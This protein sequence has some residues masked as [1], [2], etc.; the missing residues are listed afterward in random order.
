MFMARFS[1]AMHFSARGVMGVYAFTFP[2]LFFIV[3]AG[4]RNSINFFNERVLF[5]VSAFRLSLLMGVGRCFFV[6]SVQNLRYGVINAYFR[7][8]KGGETME[9]KRGLCMLRYWLWFVLLVCSPAVVEAQA[10]PERERDVVLLRDGKRI[11]CVV[12]SISNEVLYYNLP[13]RD[14]LQQV[15]LCKVMTIGVGEPKV[16]LLAQAR[17]QAEENRAAKA[18]LALDNAAAERAAAERLAAEAEAVKRAE[19]AAKKAEEEKQRVQAEAVRAAEEEQGSGAVAQETGKGNAVVPVR[20]SST[21]SW[22]DVV[23]TKE[24][25]DVKGMLFV[26]KYDITLTQSGNWSRAKSEE[27]ELGAT[28]Q[29]QKR[30]VQRR[31]THLLV[32]EVEIKRTYGEPPSIRIVGEAYKTRK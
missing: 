32:R 20:V 8:A 19:A 7:V 31:A 30:A 22:Q 21:D 12:V 11:D 4:F 6:L 5:F 14:G 23:V 18:A 3:K 27:M 29:L 10:P 13:G 15:E 25:A 9:L 17:V 26:D 2:L 28:I 1:W 24:E 16:D